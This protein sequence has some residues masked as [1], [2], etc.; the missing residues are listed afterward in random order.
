MIRIQSVLVEIIL[1]F[2]CDMGLAFSA[3]KSQISSLQISPVNLLIF[4]ICFQ[5]IVFINGVESGLNIQPKTNGVT[6]AVP[7]LTSEPTRII[8]DGNICVPWYERHVAYRHFWLVLLP[9]AQ[10]TVLPLWLCSLHAV[11]D[12]GR[13][14]GAVYHSQLLYK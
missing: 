5:M 12:G 3:N 9:G 8:S 2:S 6:L 10:Q 7:T 4:I 14:Q 1:T 13:F 11:P